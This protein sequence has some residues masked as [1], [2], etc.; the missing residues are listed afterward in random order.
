MAT[1]IEQ[2]EL[3]VQ[4]NTASAVSGLEALSETLGK[5]KTAAKGGMGLTSVSKRLESLNTALS[6]LNTGNF[7]KISK[8]AESLEKLKSVSGVKISP[9]I[10]NQLSKISAAADTLNNTNFGGIQTMKNALAPLNN[11]TSSEGLK[12]TISQLKSA[13]K[14]PGIL[15]GADWTGMRGQI[16]Q[17][18]NAL[19]PLKT[20]EVGTGLGTAVSQ[21]RSVT[22]VSDALDKVDWSKFTVQIQQLSNALAPLA[23]QLNTIGNAFSQLPTGIR[24][25]VS[26]TNQLTSANSG[27]TRSYTSLW[28]KASVFGSVMKRGAS[29]I[30][31]C[32]QQS[33]QYVEDVNLFDASMGKYAES[34]QNYAEKVGEVLG[35]DPGEFMRNQG[36]FNTIITGFG[37]VSDKAYMMSQN[38]T[39]LSYDLAS[40]FNI[41]FDSAMKKV[42]S[43]ISGELEPMRA[44]GY[45]LSV[46]RLQE[47]ALALGITKKVS[48]MTQAEKSQLRYYAMLTQVTTAQGDMARTLNAPANQLRVLRAQITQC[49]RALGNIFIPALNAVLPYVIAVTKA[50]RKL[51]EGIASLVGFELPEVDYSGLNS[52]TGAAD[53]MDE[54]M[55]NATDTAKKLK[56]TIMGFDELNV[57]QKD[58]SKDS[59]ASSG[60][61]SNDLGIDLPS[62][63]FLGDAVSNRVDSIIAQIKSCLQ[64]ITAIVSGFALAIGTI[65]VV[66]GANIPVGLGLMAAGAVGLAA[67]IAANWN[68]MSQRLASV[69]TVITGVLG[70]FLLAVGAFL[71]F[72]G[73][74]VPLGIGLMAAGAV[75]LGTAATINWK[76][77]NGNLVNALS[78]L[79]GVIGGALLGIGALL[80]FSGADIPLGIGLMAVGAVNMAA[81]VGLNWNA[82]SEPLRKAI[83]VLEAVIG[84]AMLV[85]GAIA[86]FTGV[87]I[88][89]GVAMMVIGATSLASAVALNW[90]ALTGDVKNALA[91]LTALVSG[92]LIG[93]GAVLA[94]ACPEA[95][96]VGI[97]MMAAGAVGV[98]STAG[99]NWGSLTE[100]VKSVLKEIGIAVGGSLLAVGAILALSNPVAM[101]IGIGMMIAGA[102]SL[103]AGAALNWGAIGEKVKSC[104]VTI[105]KMFA[106]ASLAALGV[107]LLG[108]GIGTPL[109]LGLIAAGLVGLVKP[110]SF[111]VQNLV[112]L[113]SDAVNGITTG[114]QTA[115]SNLQTVCSNLFQSLKDNVTSAMDTVKTA[116]VEKW[117]AVTDFMSTVPEKIGNAVNA[118]GAWFGGLPDKIAYSLGFAL[119][120]TLKWAADTKTAMEENVSQAVTSAVQWFSGLPERISGGLESARTSIAA[121]G[122][123]V[124]GSVTEAAS[125]S[126]TTAQTWFTSLPER[127]SSSISGTYERVAMWGAETKARFNE[128]AASIITETIMKFSDFAQKFYDSISK[129]GEAIA[130][131]GTDMVK[132]AKKAAGDVVNAVV[133]GIKELPNKLKALGKDIVDG[134]VQG[135]K[136]AWKSITDAVKSFVDSFVNGFKNGLGIHSPSTV[137]QSIGLNVV[138]GLQNGLRNIG[139]VFTSAFST[140]GSWVS[141]FGKN[142]YTWGSDLMGNMVSGISSGLRTLKDKVSE[143]A[144]TIRSYLHFS[145]PDVGPLADFNTWMPDMMSQLAG[146][147]AKDTDKVRKQVESLAGVMSLEPTIQANVNAAGGTP[148]VRTNSGDNTA[149]LA[150]AVYNAVSAALHEQNSGE[151][152]GT[153]IVINLGN[154]QIASFMVKQNRRAAL[155]SGG[156]A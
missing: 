73:A 9:S 125:Q 104:L 122:T 82:M 65:L 109:G 97:A 15:S 149:E 64:E 142:M 60:L 94:F 1:T 106:G 124:Y 156:R 144:S 119:G 36:T 59:S 105:T 110:E 49:E 41:S 26:A 153:P 88:P 100:K 135:L 93:V 62:Y 50:V 16:E 134:F 150:N 42:Q 79:T 127:I 77:L 146:G 101:P 3:E 112:K 6:A 28:A 52:I 54:S 140:I 18:V 120:H 126:V 38:L 53:D 98:V 74:N 27:A 67:T 152:S 113:G 76:F 107:M 70:G 57:L 89:L 11:V 103:A 154:E 115:W 48:A 43:G 91:T 24:Q 56:R 116:V 40:F 63:D 78:I 58:T 30:A 2:L 10:A 20:L 130:K 95:M 129:T 39:Q 114:V 25:L 117:N 136:D 86:A 123:N 5:V 35:I 139:S 4:S 121:W 90:N 71:A 8:V 145:Q 17:M 132:K 81:A 138:A 148:A 21:L 80:A 72:S 118:V 19:T 44:L 99:L 55:E 85:F 7:D 13:A 23:T 96:A 108:T 131:W 111:T 147:I 66:T 61:G 102:A 33:N 128:A 84:G 12:N 31:S 46:A 92:A 34:A 37:V 45:D 75:S 47:E 151:D 69:L 14:L 133:K 32:I 143:A 51:A 83:G 141:G 155:I 22:K 137:F 29:M 68:G 87:D